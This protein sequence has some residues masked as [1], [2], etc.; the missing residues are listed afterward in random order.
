MSLDESDTRNVTVGTVS[1][2]SRDNGRE[3]REECMGPTMGTDVTKGVL[4]EAPV[5]S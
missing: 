2:V 4:L 1:G 3:E 5:S